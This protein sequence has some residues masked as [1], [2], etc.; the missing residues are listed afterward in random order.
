[1]RRSTVAAVAL[2]AL[3]IFFAM[4]WKGIRHRKAVAPTSGTATIE[5][6]DVGQGDAALIRSPEGK[7]A[8]VDAGPSNRVVE[9]LRDR[10]VKSLDLVVVSH[11]H[12][13]H[14]GGMAAVVRAF[15]PRVFLD[16]DS[17]HVTPAYVKLLEE[18][19]KGGITAIRAGP[20]SR[21]ISLGSVAITV[22]PMGPENPHEENNNSVGFRVQFGG[23]SA[24]LTGDS[25]RAERRWWMQNCPNL[26]ADVDVLK[27]A[28][29]GS[30]NGTDATWLELTRPKLAVAS[31][32]L[33]NDFGH[34]HAETLDLLR[35]FK[36]PLDR[37]DLSGSIEIRTDGRDWSVKG[38]PAP[39][40]AP[41]G[42]ASRPGI[43][44]R[45]VDLNLATEDELRAIPGIGP[46]LARRIMA[47][48]PY[49]SVEDL[50]SVPDFGEKRVDHLRPFITVD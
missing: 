27:L 9:T 43:K 38:S 35:S 17:P 31:L 25:E 33:D 21:S 32:G 20:K 8:L 34:P 14:Y 24:L 6:L 40:R 5:F 4:F 19:R 22:L 11:H 2:M 13:D 41:P 45:K 37:T 15:R 18:I 10:G 42:S 12:I 29:H 1:M 48:R 28:H 36:I 47:R 50:R 26:C 16:A 49:R 39:S 30:R 46:A 7:T 23:F 3:L 44:P